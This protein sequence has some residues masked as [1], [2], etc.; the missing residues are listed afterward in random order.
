MPQRQFVLP[1]PGFTTKEGDNDN[2]ILRLRMR[3]SP[4][5]NKIKKNHRMLVVVFR[6]AI[7]NFKNW[8]IPNSPP[9]S[10]I[11]LKLGLVEHLQYLTLLKVLCFIVVILIPMDFPP[12]NLIPQSS[13]TVLLALLSQNNFSLHSEL[14]TCM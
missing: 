9:D 11:V 3:L 8:Y 6:F 4:V 12:F 7:I 13:R 1:S 10:C 14:P 5:K 2:D